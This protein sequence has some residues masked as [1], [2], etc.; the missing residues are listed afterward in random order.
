MIDDKV[1]ARTPIV[2]MFYSGKRAVIAATSIRSVDPVGSYNDEG[3][4]TMVKMI[5][6][7]HG[8]FPD[9]HWAHQLRILLQ[10]VTSMVQAQ[11]PDY[12]FQLPFMNVTI[13]LLVLCK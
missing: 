2:C 7:I 9:Y 6:R 1:S 12:L 3:V 11:S 10:A 13:L 4:S 8:T 5:I